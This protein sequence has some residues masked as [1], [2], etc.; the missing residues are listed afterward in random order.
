[1]TSTEEENEESSNCDQIL[2]QDGMGR[3]SVLV[4]DLEEMP[5]SLT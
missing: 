3:D 1:M 2:C 4:H 5:I